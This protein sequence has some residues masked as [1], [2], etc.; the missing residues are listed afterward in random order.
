MMSSGLATVAKNSTNTFSKIQSQ[1]NSTAATIKNKMGGAFV[2]ASEKSKYFGHSIDELKGKLS[3]VNKVKFGTVLK[4]E[5]KEASAEAKNLGNQIRKMEGRGSSSGGGMF[6]HLMPYLGAFA[7]ASA[8]VGFA[9]Q[10]VGAAMDFQKVKT[11]FG[12]L[13]GGKSTGDQLAGD[14]RGLKQDTVMGPAVYKNAQTMLAFGVNNREIV[15]DL[16][17]LGDVSMGDANRLQH[18]TLAFSEV[19]AQGRLT[20]K[21]VRQMSLQGFNP[22]KEMSVMTGKSMEDLRK[23]MK[24]GAITASMVSKAYEHATGPLGRFHGMLDKVG[25]TTV[26]K[27]QKLKGQWLN[28]KIGVGEMLLPV[29]DQT[30]QW[31]SELLKVLNIHKSISDTLVGEKGGIDALVGAITSMNEGN[32]VRKQLLTELVAEYPQWFSQLDIEKVKNSELLGILDKVNSAY[33]DRI[34]IATSKEIENLYKNESNT[35]RSKYM[36]Y[37]TAAELARTGHPEY[38]WKELSAS[39]KLKA[40]WTHSF[41]NGRWG[42]PNAATYDELAKDNFNQ[43]QSANKGLSDQQGLTGMAE[44]TQLINHAKELDTSTNFGKVKKALKT[45]AAINEFLSETLKAS[46]LMGNADSNDP[47]LKNAY[48]AYDISKLSGMVAKIDAAGIKVGKGA[49]IGGDSTKGDSDKASRSI[50]S[51]GPRTI[52]INGVKFM[53]KLELHTATFGEGKEQIQASLEEMFLRILN[54]GASVQN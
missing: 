33:D 9:K 45:T 10:S 20:G 38:A 49:G 25:E 43:W 35:A 50:A 47:A 36:H 41:A 23:E 1:V 17:M 3:D 7:L 16:R 6:R 42:S 51:G 11:T 44:K 46:A 54:S 39:E 19:Q 31:G 4:K 52:N 12:V 48:K 37:S 53:D 29:V 40:G 24:S 32:I 21:E 18:L 28:L 34:K 5:F 8:G 30:M 13:T 22:L 14:L 15:K 2:S 26:G 27:M